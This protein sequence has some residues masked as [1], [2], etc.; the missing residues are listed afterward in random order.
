[1]SQRQAVLVA[2]LV[3]PACVSISDVGAALRDAMSHESGELIFDSHKLAKA[4]GKPLEASQ[5]SPS[6]LLDLAF[7]GSEHSR[8]QRQL[9]EWL[10]QRCAR[11]PQSGS[12]GGLRRECTKRVAAFAAALQQAGTAPGSLRAEA[13]VALGLGRSATYMADSGRANEEAAAD[14]KQA[15]NAA[16][17]DPEL[18]ALLK[19]PEVA[20]ALERIAANPRAVDEYENSPM[21]KQALDKLN[22]LLSG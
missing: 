9:Q 3:I 11:L 14:V 5:V 12:E 7:S 4:F 20:E 17:A 1:M 6:A 18:Q 10:M 16:K 21:V 22:A 2:V 8:P 19:I 15:V 13:A